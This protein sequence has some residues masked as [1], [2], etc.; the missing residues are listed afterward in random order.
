[1]GRCKGWQDYHSEEYVNTFC[2]RGDLRSY[3]RADPANDEVLG[4]V[5]EMGV[6]ETKAAIDAAAAAFKT[7]SK[8]TAKVCLAAPLEQLCTA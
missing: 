3:K 5:P 1:V 4:T 8:T 2:V 7:W 6:A